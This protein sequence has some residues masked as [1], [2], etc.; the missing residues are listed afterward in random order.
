MKYLSFFYG[1]FDATQLN[2]KN[3]FFD[4]RRNNI[5]YCS[6]S[7]RTSLET[8]NKKTLVKNFSVNIGRIIS[9]KTFNPNVKFIRK[10]L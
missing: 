10:N 6:N 2:E 5:V 7:S 4:S 9:Y 3:N 8:F 1:N